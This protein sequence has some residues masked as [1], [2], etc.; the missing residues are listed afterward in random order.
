MPGLQTLI[1]RPGSNPTQSQ[2]LQALA[3]EIWHSGANSLSGLYCLKS[4]P[5]GIKSYPAIALLSPGSVYGAIRIN[6]VAIL[7]CGSENAFSFSAL[8]TLIVYSVT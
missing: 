4:Y 8:N 6:I 5:I 1:T 3:Q 7:N 2:I